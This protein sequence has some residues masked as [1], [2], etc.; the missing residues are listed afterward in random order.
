MR[1]DEENEC[2]A[3]ILSP[4]L[5]SYLNGWS[6]TGGS[7]VSKSTHCH[8]CRHSD[9]HLA[10]LRDCHSTHTFRVRKPRTMQARVQLLAKRCVLI[11]ALLL[12]RHL[13]FGFWT[14]VSFLI[15]ANSFPQWVERIVACTSLSL[16]VPLPSSLLLYFGPGT[17]PQHVNSSGK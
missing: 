11:R 14:Q 17:C 9:S 5:I 7:K 8:Y 12:F 13:P 15:S 10:L 16:S 1:N 6:A 4:S 3:P 2:Q